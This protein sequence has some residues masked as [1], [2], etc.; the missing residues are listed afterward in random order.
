MSASKI[1]SDNIRLRE[2]TLEGDNNG[3][4]GL[5][6]DEKILE[7]EYLLGEYKKRYDDMVDRSG[8]SSDSAELVEKS[9]RYED[10]EGEQLPKEIRFDLNS[11]E[12][13]KAVHDKR[14]K[15]LEKAV[16]KRDTEIH[17]LQSL[18][19]ER[20]VSNI[21]DP[22]TRLVYLEEYSRNLEEVVDTTVTF[23][24]NRC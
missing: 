20:V 8:P 18:L 12:A 13:Q 14:T 9:S 5:Q 22:T 19:G 24:K 11:S 7:L 2:K 17:H 15:D 23:L 3:G 10:N 6:K 16:Q 1:A 21:S 4:S